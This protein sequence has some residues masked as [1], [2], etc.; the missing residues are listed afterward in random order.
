MTTIIKRNRKKQKF[1]AKKLKKSIQQAFFDAGL[2][3]SANKAKID[4]VV[5]AV[6]KEIKGKQ[7][8]TSK[9]IKKVVLKNL[10]K[11]K[12]TALSSWRKF[13]KKY[14]KQ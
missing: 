14:K 4:K 9:A 12:K 2:S 8:V 5:K 11:T 3:V 7:K 6:V 1:D 10:G 13:D